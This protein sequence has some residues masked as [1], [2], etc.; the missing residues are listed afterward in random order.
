MV[1]STHDNGIKF[2]RNAESFNNPLG[3]FKICGCVDVEKRDKFRIDFPQAGFRNHFRAHAFKK[4]LNAQLFLFELLLYWFQALT[5]VY[6]AQRLKPKF[7]LRNDDIQA[8]LDG[9][10]NRCDHLS[11]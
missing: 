6:C 2:K 3:F 4:V 11:F 5:A 7:C 8:G 10:Q 1:L 9:I